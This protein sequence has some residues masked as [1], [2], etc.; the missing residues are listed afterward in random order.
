MFPDVL[1]DRRGSLEGEYH[2][3]LRESARPVQYAR[4]GDH[5]TLRDN[6]NETSEELQNSRVIKPMSRPTPWISSILAIPKRNQNNISRPKRF[7]QSNSE[8]QLSYTNHCNLTTWCQSV[9]D[10]D[11][12]NGF[13]NI[14][15]DEE[16]S[17]MTIFHT[18]FGRYRW[19]T[20][21]FDMS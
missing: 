8:T 20:M 2:I 21:P 18:E 11:S 16:S 15:L 4:R 12:R 9:F 10:R 17:Y 3:V 19:C 6:N 13:G 14:N 5:V 7:E 1:D